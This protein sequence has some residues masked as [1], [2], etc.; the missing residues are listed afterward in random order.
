MR[1]RVPRA[2]S[3]RLL[4]TR[5]PS[6]ESVT[7]S[8]ETHVRALPSSPAIYTDW[9]PDS[10]ADQRSAAP[11]NQHPSAADSGSAR[12]LRLSRARCRVGVVAEARARAAWAPLERAECGVGARGSSLWCGSRPTRGCGS[13]RIGGGRGARPSHQSEI[14]SAARTSACRPHAEEGGRASWQHPNPR[15]GCAAGRHCKLAASRPGAGRWRSRETS[16]AQACSD[17]GMAR[18]D[19]PA[20]GDV[21]THRARGDSAAPAGEGEC[22]R[23]GGVGCPGAH[24]RAKTRGVSSN[25]R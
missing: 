2:P 16:G 9:T 18:E 8:A 17:R 19:R 12:T 11:Q 4:P 13:S 3:T 23:R 7:D 20:A 1:S 10:Q 25:R 22:A 21:C 15:L 5:S 6:P 24:L 14:D